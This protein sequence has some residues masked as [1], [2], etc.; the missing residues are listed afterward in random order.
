MGY[1][2]VALQPGATHRVS[3]FKRVY[4][5]T[6]EPLEVVRTDRLKGLAKNFELSAYVAK[7]N[8]AS[9]TEACAVLSS[10]PKCLCFRSRPNHG[11]NF[12]VS[13]AQIKPEEAAISTALIEG[14]TNPK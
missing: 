2:R 8:L 3:H 9:S 10:E 6:G 13:G 7:A 11:S 1:F 12:R 14:S 4:S 5:D